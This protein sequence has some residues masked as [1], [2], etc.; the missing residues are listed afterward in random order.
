MNLDFFSGLSRQ[1]FDMLIVLQLAFWSKHSPENYESLRAW[2]LNF[3]WEHLFWTFLRWFRGENYLGGLEKRTKHKTEQK[4]K[5]T[6]NYSPRSA[7]KLK[8]TLLLD[9]FSLRI[10]QMVPNYSPYPYKWAD[11][12][13]RKIFPQFWATKHFS[14]AITLACI[15]I[16][17]TKL[18]LCLL[19]TVLQL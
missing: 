9:N 10:Q 14:D 18:A 19:L 4:A 7:R 8:S 16:S 6:D 3:E 15:L 2:E 1:N 13:L 12:H 5:Q 11:F 17:L